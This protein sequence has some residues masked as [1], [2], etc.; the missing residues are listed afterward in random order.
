MDINIKLNVEK[1]AKC[2]EKQALPLRQKTKTSSNFTEVFKYLPNIDVVKILQ[3]N[4]NRTKIAA[5]RHYCTSGVL[6]TFDVE[7]A[8]AYNL[9]DNLENKIIL[10]LCEN[11]DE[12]IDVGKFILQNKRPD[13]IF[14]ILEYGERIIDIIKDFQVAYLL[15][16][17]DKI[18]EQ[19]LWF[20]KNATILLFFKINW[21][22]KGKK[23]ELAS[24]KEFNS[25]LSDIFDKKH[26]QLL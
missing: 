16:N 24:N 26:K 3:E 20:N 17:A 2:L 11:K 23:I 7:Y 12:M 18:A 9:P 5:N 19:T 14:G 21:Y 22:H 13:T 15:G 4:T 25:L 10:L 8:M 1:I 6:R